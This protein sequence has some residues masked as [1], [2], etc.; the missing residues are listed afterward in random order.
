MGCVKSKD[1]GSAKGHSV[2]EK[3][4][5]MEKDM[6]E[7]GEKVDSAGDQAAEV[8]EEVEDAGE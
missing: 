3:K 8:K 6:D 7:A 5:K 2:I 1:S 4:E